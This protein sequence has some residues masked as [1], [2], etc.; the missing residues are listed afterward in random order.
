MLEDCIPL[1]QMCLQNSRVK[2]LSFYCGYLTLRATWVAIIV[3][4]LLACM[5]EN[6]DKSIHQQAFSLLKDIPSTDE[7]R[8]MLLT[9]AP[10]IREG[11]VNAY[12]HSIVI[13]KCRIK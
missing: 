12:L 2:S 4:A 13:L 1:L 3:I 5:V 7:Q 11:L 8:I 10:I 6:F 9:R